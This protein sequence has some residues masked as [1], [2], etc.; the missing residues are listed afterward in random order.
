MHNAE[1]ERRAN[2]AEGGSGPGGAAIRPVMA[3]MLEVCGIIDRM[4]AEVRQLVRSG[5]KRQI[6]ESA[7]DLLDCE[8]R[9]RRRTLESRWPQKGLSTC[10]E[11]WNCEEDEYA[12]ADA[13]EGSGHG[14]SA[15][16][17]TSCGRAAIAGH[18]GGRAGGLL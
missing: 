13:G 2:A 17:H 8:R 4:E 14:E 5:A 16:G 11:D 1:I 18:A 9:S 7:L 10:R 12:S 6:I 3:D 15:D